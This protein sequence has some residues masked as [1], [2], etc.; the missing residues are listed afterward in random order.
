MSHTNLKG[1]EEASED[2]SERHDESN[3]VEVKLFDGA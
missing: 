1:S 2:N 3:R